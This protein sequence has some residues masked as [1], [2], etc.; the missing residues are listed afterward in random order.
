MTY[1]KDLLSSRAVLKPGLYAL[2]PSTGLVDNVVPG[3]EKCRLSFLCSPK[4]GASFIQLLGE[5]QAGG[6]A[7][8]YGTGE[9]VEV[10]IYVLDGEGRLTI[11]IGR[12]SEILEPGGFAFAPPGV[13]L[14]LVN[15]SKSTTRFLIHKQRHIPHPQPDRKPWAVFGQAGQ[16]EERPFNGM[17]NVFI[18]DF[19]PTDQ[20]F[21]LNFHILSFL[22]GGSHDFVETHLQEHGAYIYEGEGLY[23]LNDDWRPVKKGD[24][25]WMGAFCKQACYAVGRER[26]SYIYSKDC[27]RDAAL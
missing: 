21:D 22:P 16:I 9:D 4:I 3:F 10:F 17:T 13:G 27:N 19:L 6:R 1:P 8:S 26:L 25:I 20:A 23:L 5:I 15:S 7:D 12:Q 2:I 14:S 18:K 24:F 11:T